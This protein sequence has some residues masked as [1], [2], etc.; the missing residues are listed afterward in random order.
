MERREQICIDELKKILECYDDDE[1]SLNGKKDSAVCLEHNGNYWMVY[2]SERNS[3]R[4]LKEY[5]NIVEACLD[6]IK[7]MSYGDDI[8]I[9]T[10]KFLDAIM[11]IRL[12]G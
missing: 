9:M 8:L 6:M 4:R 5:N 10:N 3:N 11:R 2:E 1:Y 7:R 12:A